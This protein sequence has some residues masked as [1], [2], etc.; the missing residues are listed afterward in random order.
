MYELTIKELF[1]SYILERFKYL[2][3]SF[4]NKDYN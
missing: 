2:H 3:L 4:T 1:Y